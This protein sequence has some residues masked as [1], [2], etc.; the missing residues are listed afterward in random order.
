M[1]G[2]I[3]AMIEELQSVTALMQDLREE[4]LAGSL[5]YTGKIQGKDVVVSQCG[6]GK[7]AA[8]I[9][10][11]LLIEH[12]HP[13][14]VINV[15][16]GGGLKDFL[17]P[18][19][20]VIADKLTYHDWDTTL[21]DGN[22]VSF[23]DAQYV[24][25]TDHELI[26][27]ARDIL[28]DLEDDTAAYIGPIVTGDQFIGNNEDAQFIIEHFPDAYC[29]DMES[30]AVAHACHEFDTSFVIIRSFSDIVTKQGS[31]IDYSNYK[32]RAVE[33]AAAMCR[34]LIKEL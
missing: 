33:R 2:I 19:D 24:F 10:T 5:C 8:G 4:K 25:T 29:T 18:L 7:T 32:I 3:T 1:I 12:Y 13:D 20:I 16:C 26:E 17:K 6:I 28:E 11:A 14:Y 21:I 15:G 9:Y 30:C 22:T 27:K 34:R 31:S 23:D